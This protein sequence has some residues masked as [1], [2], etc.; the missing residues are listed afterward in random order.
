MS[1]ALLLT[2]EEAAALLRVGRTVMW[3]LVR[4]SAVQTIS[5]GRSRRVVAADLRRFVSELAA[6]VDRH[7]GLIE[8]TPPGSKPRTTESD[9]R[10]AGTGR[11]A[12]TRRAR[13]DSVRPT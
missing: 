9:E 11:V 6:E 7:Q 10:P 5:I 4:N 12:E 8:G 13:R 1:E 3:D 2:V